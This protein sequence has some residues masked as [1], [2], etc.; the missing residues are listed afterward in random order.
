MPFVSHPV[1]MTHRAGKKILN[2]CKKLYTIVISP[3]EI[4]ALDKKYHVG[5]HDLTEEHFDEKNVH[6]GPGEVS[7]PALNSLFQ[8]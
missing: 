3:S 8:E 5:R 2:I 4:N 1:S 6:Q 7:G